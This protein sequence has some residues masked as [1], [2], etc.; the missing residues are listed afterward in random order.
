MLKTRED[1]INFVKEKEGSNIFDTFV[2][3][4][5]FEDGEI[6]LERR[7][8]VNIKEYDKYMHRDIT[9]DSIIKCLKDTKPFVNYIKQ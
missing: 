2:I 1:L 7:C 6:W 5:I 8:D 4:T 9:D 3:D